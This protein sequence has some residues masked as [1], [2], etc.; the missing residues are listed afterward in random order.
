LLVREVSPR[1]AFFDNPPLVFA[2]IV[3]V[4]H[5]LDLAGEASDFS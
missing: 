3:I 2:N 4:A 5:A 1:G